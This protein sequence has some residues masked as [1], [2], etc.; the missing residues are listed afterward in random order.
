MVGETDFDLSK[1]GKT[2]YQVTERLPLTSIDTDAY[3]EVLVKTSSLDPTPSTP[4]LQA[5]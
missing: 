5:T 4:S 2:S 1:Y 3:I